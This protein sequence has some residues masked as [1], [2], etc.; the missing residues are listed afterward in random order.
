MKKFDQETSPRETTK[1]RLV[2]KQDVGHGGIRNDGFAHPSKL[3]AAKK[4]VSVS[5]Q[6][7]GNNSD[8]DEDES[9]DDEDAGDAEESD[10]DATDNEDPRVFRTSGKSIL[11]RQ[12]SNVSGVSDIS[13]DAQMPRPPLAGLR[14]AASSSSGTKRKRTTSELSTGTVLSTIEG[15]D[16]DTEVEYPRKRMSRRLSNENGLLNYDQRVVEV[17]EDI[18]LAEYSKA[19]EDSDED[20]AAGSDSSSDT[21]EDHNNDDDDADLDDF[22]VEEAEEAM[23]LQ[24]EEDRDFNG[25]AASS[26][27]GAESDIELP[28]DLDLGFLNS[29]MDDIFDASE[30]FFFRSLHS[31]EPETSSRK[32]SDASA[33]RVRFEDEV[34]I[35]T[36]KTYSSSAGSSETDIDIFPDLLDNP[37]KSQDELPATLRSQMDDDEDADVGHNAASSDGEGSVWDFGEERASENF[38]SWHDEPGSDSEE[39]SGSDLSGYDCMRYLMYFLISVLLTHLSKLM[40]TLLTKTCHHQTSSRNRVLSSTAAHPRPLLQR[41]RRPSPFQEA[42]IVVAVRLWARSSL[43]QTRPWRS[44]IL[45]RSN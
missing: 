7:V 29:E 9:G 42:S 40:A 15:D 25:T 3:R 19:I 24:E 21:A 45:I 4:S 16:D 39:E 11:S 22:D 27:A 26:V 32:K 41:L 10:E 20:E 18:D 1:S 30:S 17:D 36:H 2:N 13:Y 34:E 23:I 37:F 44:L 12:D 33:R 43:T 28:D 38:F 5:V 14:M 31:E 35:A 8:Q 6:A